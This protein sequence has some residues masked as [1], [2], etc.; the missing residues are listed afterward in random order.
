MSMFLAHGKATHTHE[1]FFFYCFARN[2]RKKKPEY[3]CFVYNPLH[4]FMICLLFGNYYM[5]IDGVDKI[6][7]IP[8]F[9]LILLIDPF[10]Y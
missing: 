9:L 8:V 2:V 6:L 7:L 4:N 10:S 1:I 3:L 5:N